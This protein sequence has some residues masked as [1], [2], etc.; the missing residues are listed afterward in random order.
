MFLISKAENLLLWPQDL[1]V[2]AALGTEEQTKK[3]WREHFYFM[4]KDYSFYLGLA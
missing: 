3:L 4:E 2:K 1:L